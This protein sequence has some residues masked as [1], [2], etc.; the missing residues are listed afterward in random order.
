MDAG[1]AV[2]APIKAEHEHADADTALLQQPDVAA[3]TAAAAAPRVDAAA[4]SSVC[5]PPPPR[6]ACREVPIRLLTLHTL[7][8]LLTAPFLFRVCVTHPSPLQG[9]EGQSPQQQHESLEYPHQEMMYP[10][11]LVSAQAPLPTQAHTHTSRTII[12]GGATTDEGAETHCSHWF[13][14][15]LYCTPTVGGWRLSTIYA[16]RCTTPLRCTR[17]C[18]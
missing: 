11:T 12:Y 2:Q 18:L 4:E 7:A 16:R 9:Y 13:N 6:L 5:P 3:P 8:H 15:T 10:P 1:A 17:V 14:T